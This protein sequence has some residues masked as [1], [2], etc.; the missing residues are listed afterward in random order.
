MYV[1]ACAA[2]LAN[3]DWLHADAEQLLTLTNVIEVVGL[4]LTLDAFMRGGDEKAEPLPP[5]VPMVQ[6]CAA[7]AVASTLVTFAAAGGQLGEHTA[8]LG[9]FGNLC[10]PTRAEPLSLIHI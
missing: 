5:P 3:V 10:A 4:K 7:V 2:Q 1:R 9:G 8:Y 6:T